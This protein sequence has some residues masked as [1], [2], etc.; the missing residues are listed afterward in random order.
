MKIMPVKNYFVSGIGTDIGKTIVSAVLVEAL[1]A[2]YWKPIQ[3]GDLTNS[4][5]D[6]VFQMISNTQSKFHENIFALQTPVSPHYAAELDGIEIKL[7][8]LKKPATANHL[9]IEGA[10]GLMVPLNKTELVVDLIE[11]LPCELILVMNNYLGSINHSLMSFE[12]LKDRNISIK[13]VIFCGDTYAPGEDFILNYTKLK[14]LGRVPQME[15]ITKEEIYKI[16]Q[17]FKYLAND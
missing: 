5:K 14:F 8:S 17:Q 4:D 13:G 7:D 9:I 6:K 11:Q 12:V 15:N 3:A 2:D 16:A 10:G 1:Q